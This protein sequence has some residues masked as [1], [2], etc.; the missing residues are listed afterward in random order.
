MYL[1]WDIWI[2]LKS[3]IIWHFKLPKN[4]FI[5][6]KSI[7]RDPIIFIYFFII[8]LI[9]LQ[10][11]ITSWSIQVP[12]CIVKLQE[13]TFSLRAILQLNN[14]D[15]YFTILHS[16]VKQYSWKYNCNSVVV[17]HCIYYTINSFKLYCNNI[18]A[19]LLQSLGNSWW[20]SSGSWI[21]NP[22]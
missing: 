15:V 8:A 6:D 2:I 16:I 4:L 9:R 13:Y 5:W 21:C 19:L 7:Q 10:Y 12:Y 22:L 3:I 11:Y 17:V 18:A 20:S 1:S 14:L